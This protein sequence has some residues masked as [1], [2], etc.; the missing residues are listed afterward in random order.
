MP[1]PNRLP[2]NPSP[3]APPSEIQPSDRR[4]FHGVLESLALAHAATLVILVS[5]AV[6]GGANWARTAVSA[7]GSFGVLITVASFASQGAH[8]HRLWQ[9]LFWLWPLALLDAYVIVSVLN[10]SYRE[11]LDGAA[12]FYARDASLPR[13]PLL[14]STARPDLSLDALWFFNVAYLS[15]FNLPLLVRRRRSL[16][17]LLIAI[18][19]NGVL[20]AIFGTVQKLMGAKGLYFGLLPTVQPF[21]FST[22]V[23]HNHWGAFTLLVTAT[24]IGLVYHYARHRHYR[25]FWHSPAPLGLVCIV[26]LAATIPLSTSRSCTLLVLL[27]ICSA[28]LHGLIRLVRE[29]RTRGRSVGLSVAGVLVGLGL[30][31]GFSYSLS[32]EIVQVRL[33]QTREQL[34]KMNA[35]RQYLPRAVLYRD[36]WRLTREKVWLGWGMASYP[37]AFYHYNTQHFSSNGPNR[38]FH[39]AH[40]DWLQSVAEVGLLGTALL[41]LC[42]GVPL[43]GSRRALRA[44]PLVIYLL[45]G[46]ALLV[47]Y[48][49]LEF[50]FGNRAVVIAFWVCFFSALG[51]ARLKPAAT[52]H[53]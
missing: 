30:A 53:R 27:L 41:L 21:F 15:G 33:T 28:A 14:P 37:T 31:V 24:T 32:Q 12:S 2:A 49:T 5:W 39:D 13:W 26:F 46:G 17:L 50:P 8:A 36:T 40:S 23:Y 52:A 3:S 22:F 45:S 4:S 16:R 34:T 48:A 42:A 43:Y 38:L 25:D 29:R 20:L 11:V 9:P 7:W 6:G 10:P 51:Y 19:T 1:E 47:L 44:S 18:V 35:D